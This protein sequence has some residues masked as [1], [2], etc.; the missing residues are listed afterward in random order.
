[1]T[2]GCGNGC[3]KTMIRKAPVAFD[4]PFLELRKAERV[5]YNSVTEDATEWVVLEVFGYTFSHPGPYGE[6][7]GELY[8]CRPNDC[9][10][11]VEFLGAE[12]GQVIDSYGYTEDNS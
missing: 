4:G 12:W 9:D 6:E 8:V 11:V 7:W 3:V 2:F 5:A 10:A 1:M